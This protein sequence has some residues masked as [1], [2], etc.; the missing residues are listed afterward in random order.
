[1]TAQPFRWALIFVVIVV[2]VLTQ[3]R[4]LRASEQP[5]LQ[6]K[7][8]GVSVDVHLKAPYPKAVGYDPMN[9]VGQ[10]LSIAHSGDS[11]LLKGVLVRDWPLIIRLSSE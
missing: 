10:G 2:A 4:Q 7:C 8:E 3:Q 1:M 5:Q 6:T 9:G 11:T